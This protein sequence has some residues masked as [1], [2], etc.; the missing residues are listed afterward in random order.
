MLIDEPLTENVR[1]RIEPSLKKIL[2]EICEQTGLEASE[3]LRQQII[4]LCAAYDRPV[5]VVT[6]RPGCRGR[7]R[8]RLET[9]PA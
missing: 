9:I 7:P 3:F 2:R 4:D 6:C 8:K 5:S 1:V